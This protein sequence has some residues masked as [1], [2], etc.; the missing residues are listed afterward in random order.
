MGVVTRDRVTLPLFPSPEDAYVTAIIP[1]YGMNIVNRCYNRTT[2][3]HVE[4]RYV[5]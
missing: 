1:E 4:I 3:Y 2:P 5:Q